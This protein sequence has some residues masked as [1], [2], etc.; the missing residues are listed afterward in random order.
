MA[1]GSRSAG[2]RIHSNE[3]TPMRRVARPDKVA[4]AIHFLASGAASAMTGA[5]VVVDC[6]YTI[7]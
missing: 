4:S 2:K 3:N 1:L 7:W 5:V 6:G